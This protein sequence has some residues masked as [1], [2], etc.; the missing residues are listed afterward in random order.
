[1]CQIDDVIDGRDDGV[2]TDKDDDDN[3]ST[4][5]AMSVDLPSPPII[6]NQ[7]NLDNPLLSEAFRNEYHRSHNYNSRFGALVNA[8]IEAQS[9]PP[10]P[11]IVSFLLP[12]FCG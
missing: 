11:D 7:V 1:M 9:W 3:T 12:P 4:I 6:E 2:M 5:V 10:L 8:S